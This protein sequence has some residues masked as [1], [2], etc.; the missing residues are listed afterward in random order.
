MV[1]GEVRE[2]S[3]LEGTSPSFRAAP[4]S[5]EPLPTIRIMGYAKPN[6]RHVQDMAIGH[7]LSETQE[8]GFP[9]LTW[10]PNRQA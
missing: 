7:G 5:S 8:A 6:L 1:L 4:A 2:L 10:M 3:P 9:G